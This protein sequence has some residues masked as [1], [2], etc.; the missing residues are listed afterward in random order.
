MQRAKRREET[1]SLK[2]WI[3]SLKAYKPNVE[4]E[5]SHFSSLIEWLENYIQEES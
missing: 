5:A 1:K 4:P 3:L 2:L